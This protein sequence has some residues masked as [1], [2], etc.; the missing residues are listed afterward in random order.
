MRASV[1]NFKTAHSLTRITVQPSRLSALDTRLSLRLFAS[2]LSFQNLVLER[3]RCLPQRVQP[4]QKQPS[5][6]TASF[7]PGQAKSGL[8]ATGQ[9]FRYPRNPAAHNFFASG[10]SV[11]V[12]PR[13]RT[14]A[15]ILD[16]TAF[17]T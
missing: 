17:E 6:K 5:T 3:G 8:P 12:F 15:M 9:C 4:C 2:I 16:R 13:D 14:E 11:V 7:R 10:S 1:A